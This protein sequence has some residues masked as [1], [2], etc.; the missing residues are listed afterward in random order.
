[1]VIHKNTG[2]RLGLRIA[3]GKDSSCIPFGNPE[4]PGIFIS[5]VIPGG[6][7]ARTER[8]RIGDRILKINEKDVS[9]WT[10]PEV[11]R[12]LCAAPAPEVVLRV[13][14][15]PP[16]P[17]LDELLIHRFVI[18]SRYSHVCKKI[19]YCSVYM[20]NGLIFNIL[21]IFLGKKMNVM[22]SKL[23]VE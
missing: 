3:G 22:E 11:I 7:A 18:Y 16:P 1:V 8:L 5:R 2:S 12:A 20:T 6:A 17:G 14:H 21:T 13:R 23:L 19:S 10:H 9:D 15:D 4:E